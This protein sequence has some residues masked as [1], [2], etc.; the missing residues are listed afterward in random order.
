MPTTSAPSDTS[1]PASPPMPS[2]ASLRG[3]RRSSP[4]DVLVPGTP[5]PTTPV[6]APPPAPRPAEWADLL[7]FGLRIVRA[8]AAVPA[9]LVRRLLGG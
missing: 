6:V 4:V 3:P 9:G 8:V 5:E 1:G 7:P 2:F